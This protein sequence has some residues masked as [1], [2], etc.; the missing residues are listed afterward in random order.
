VLFAALEARPGALVFMGRTGLNAI[1]R[2]L[3][4]SV[5]TALATYSS[6]PVVIVP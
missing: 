3:K 5:A 1:Q 4:G 2:V 6:R